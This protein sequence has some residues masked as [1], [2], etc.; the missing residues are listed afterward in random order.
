M[1]LISRI[2]D[3]MLN[4]LV[5]PAKAAAG[6][7]TESFWDYECRNGRQY[8]RWCTTKATCTTTCGAWQYNTQCN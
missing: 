2:G 1:T 6:C 3:T 7:P 5:P 8:K 4:K